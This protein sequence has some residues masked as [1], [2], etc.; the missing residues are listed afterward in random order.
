LL[1]L[2]YYLHGNNYWKMIFLT[3]GIDYCCFWICV[4][5]FHL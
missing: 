3:V 4:C 1:M 2:Q 5:F